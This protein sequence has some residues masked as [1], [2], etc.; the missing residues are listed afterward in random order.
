MSDYR[1]PFC[2]ICQGEGDNRESAI[3]AVLA[4][5]HEY[6]ARCL[7]QGVLIPRRPCCICG[8]PVR[9]DLIMYYPPGM[10]IPAIN[11]D[12][13][14]DPNILMEILENIEADRPDDGPVVRRPA[15]APAPEPAP[16]LEAI[17][18]DVPAIRQDA[19]E[20]VDAVDEEDR[21]LRRLNQPRQ[22][23]TQA[24]ILVLVALAAFVIFSPMNIV[25]PVYL[26]MA[27]G[28]FFYTFTIPAA[29]A[30]ETIERVQWILSPF[31]VLLLM[32]N[33]L[34]FEV[35]LTLIGMLVGTL[36]SIAILANDD[37]GE[38]ALSY[39]ELYADVH[40][41]RLELDLF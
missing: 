25:F 17:A 3:L 35:F 23:G 14:I 7:V 26:T 27:L 34:S 21:Q 19:Q 38:L 20:A 30:N 9:L 22:P 28:G 11:S 36:C 13:V 33:H 40:D 41:F 6:C 37:D 31:C 15:P 5:Q 16:E 8:T 2:P 10:D 29:F 18:N 32:G 24:L 39:A 4:C 12:T 1:T